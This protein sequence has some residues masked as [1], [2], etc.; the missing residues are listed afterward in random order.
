MT[1]KTWQVMY[2]NVS[3]PCRSENDARLLAREL[4]KKAT[5][6]S[7]EPSRTSHLPAGSRATRLKRGCANSPRVIRISGP[8]AVRARPHLLEASPGTARSG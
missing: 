4:L 5:A 8:S 7:P 2:A 6:S 1:S 3:L